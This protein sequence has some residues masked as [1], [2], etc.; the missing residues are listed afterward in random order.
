MTLVLARRIVLFR[1]QGEGE[2]EVSQGKPRIDP[3]L[4]PVS[5][6]RAE[7]G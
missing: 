3:Y 1:E 4:L 2:Y 7:E 5:I 6:F